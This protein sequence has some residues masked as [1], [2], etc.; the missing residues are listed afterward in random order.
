MENSSLG[1]HQ[2]SV[3]PWETILPLIRKGPLAFG[4]RLLA[5]RN[6]DKVRHTECLWML[7]EGAGR[8]LWMLAQVGM[9]IG[10]QQANKCFH[11]DTAADGPESFTIGL[12]ACLC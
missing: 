4:D 2:L 12:M 6:P 11:N 5:C 1:V 7:I 3:V 8:P 10:H 9:A